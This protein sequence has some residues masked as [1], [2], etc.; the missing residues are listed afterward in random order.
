MRNL[1]DI[2]EFRR[3]RDAHIRRSVGHASE[4]WASVVIRVAVAWD[5]A[6]LRVSPSLANLE[7]RGTDGFLV[8]VSASNVRM[9]QRARA[10]RSHGPVSI[11]REILKSAT[12]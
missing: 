8:G 2:E 9:A 5:K 7:F 4:N 11:P 12:D 10:M 6:E 1:V 3:R